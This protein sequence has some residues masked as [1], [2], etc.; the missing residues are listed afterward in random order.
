MPLPDKLS[1]VAKSIQDA[2]TDSQNSAAAVATP[3]NETEIKTQ[4]IAPS[5]AVEGNTIDTTRLEVGTNEESSVV[6]ENTQQPVGSEEKITFEG[7]N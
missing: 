5:T 2:G 6:M 3:G 4:D 7:A 1:D